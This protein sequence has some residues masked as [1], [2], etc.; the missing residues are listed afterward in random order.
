MSHAQR[1]NGP[2][3]VKVQAARS[4]SEWVIFRFHAPPGAEVHV[5]GTFNGWD[6]TAT[7][8]AEDGAGVYT[9]TIRL[10]LG[11]YEY[12]FRVNGNWCDGPDHHERVPNAFGTTN[13]VLIVSR[14]TDPG[15]H[16]H[17]FARQA[18]HE[19]Q[20]LVGIPVGG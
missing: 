12:R 15:H 6:A 4:A 11:R 9:A 16:Q 18:D 1:R 7:R 19:E 20:L 3:T 14:A 17:T 13:S 8:L 5:A 2:T 10:P